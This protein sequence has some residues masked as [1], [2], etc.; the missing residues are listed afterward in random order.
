MSTCSI[1]DTSRCVEHNVLKCSRCCPT[2]Y[3]TAYGA[4][5]ASTSTSVPR[6]SAPP[7]RE[8][9][10]DDLE[11]R[12]KVAERQL[13][14]IRDE[15]KARVE[16][17]CKTAAGIFFGTIF[18]LYF[19]SLI[20]RMIWATHTDECDM[21]HNRINYKHNVFAANIFMFIGGVAFMVWTFGTHP[22]P[23]PRKLAS[24]R[25]ER[26]DEEECTMSWFQ[27]LLGIAVIGLLITTCLDPLVLWHYK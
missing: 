9:S 14:N 25:T 1:H 27:T 19:F 2:Y 12:L 7:A 18:A 20:V 21:V 8:L 4:T 26:D 15:E 17:R 23:Q 3:A 10:T 13:K 11:A 22:E 24:Q 5:S 16:C 6:A